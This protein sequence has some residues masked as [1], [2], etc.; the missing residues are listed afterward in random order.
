METV[1]DG[2]EV[3]VRASVIIARNGDLVSRDSDIAFTRSFVEAYRERDPRCATMTP[4]DIIEHMFM[5][6]GCEIGADSRRRRQHGE[7]AYVV[8]VD[9]RPPKRLDWKVK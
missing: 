8:M 5:M 1:V 9:D 2:D 4:P 7:W 6:Q 3:V